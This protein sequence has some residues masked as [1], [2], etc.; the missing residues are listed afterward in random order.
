MGLKIPVNGFL[1]IEKFSINK[2]FIDY[3]SYY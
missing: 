1:K 2:N 3:K